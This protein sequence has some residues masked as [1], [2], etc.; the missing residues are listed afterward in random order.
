MYYREKLWKEFLKKGCSENFDEVIH[1]KSISEDRCL[2]KVTGYK[3]ATLPK[4]NS[5]KCIL[6]HFKIC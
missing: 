2:D 5:F 4:M 1:N 6:K 3:L